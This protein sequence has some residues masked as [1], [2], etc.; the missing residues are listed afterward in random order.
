MV[1][2]YREFVYSFIRYL[3]F[4]FLRAELEAEES[5]KNSWG[6]L[7]NRRYFLAN[8]FNDSLR[9]LQIFTVKITHEPADKVCLFYFL[10]L[11]FTPY[12]LAIDTFTGLSPC[13]F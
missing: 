8:F 1:F 7:F 9:G 3:H 11:P 10:E 5:K 6:I 2:L 12:Y 13:P 4:S